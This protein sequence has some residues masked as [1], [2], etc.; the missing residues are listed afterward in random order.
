M[1]IYLLRHPPVDLPSGICY[2]WLDVPLASDGDRWIEQ[3][4]ERLH[5][6]PLTAV[7]SSPSQRCRLVAEA[8]ARRHRLPCVVDDRLRELHFGEWEGLSWQEIYLDPAG[9][10]WFDDYRHVSTTG[11]ES[12]EAHR[13]RVL[14]FISEQLADKETT[15]LIVTHAGTIRIFAMHYEQISC[16]EALQ[17]EIPY[18]SLHVYE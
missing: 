7:Y 15:N 11:G 10:R 18:G 16:E 6:T 14:S 3:A 17:K 5:E 2:G 4:V 9:K 1:S 8:V 13:A 12:H